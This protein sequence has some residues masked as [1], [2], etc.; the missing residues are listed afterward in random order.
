M[1]FADLTEL[2]AV[3][4][5]E[6]GVHTVSHP[7][8]PLL[9][10]PD[11]GQEIAGGYDELRERFT[12]VVPILAVPFGL[13]DERTLRA[14][15]AAGM[16][17]SCSVSGATLDRR[18]P[19]YALPRICMARGDTPATLGLRLLGLPDLMRRCAGRSSA[20]Y[21]DLPSATT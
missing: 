21:P 4:G 19:Q 16:T 6:V 10:D 20:P 15:H 17:A 5:V 7:V 9:P 13:Y 18:A 11:L 3:P 12:N 14:A 8:L 2:A 1:T